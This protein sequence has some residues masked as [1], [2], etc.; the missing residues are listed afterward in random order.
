MPDPS[1]SRR[2]IHRSD[3]KK[4]NQKQINAQDAPH[5]FVIS[6]Y[7]PLAEKLDESENSPQAEQGTPGFPSLS[8]SGI[9]AW[10]VGIGV[11][12]LAGG[13]GWKFWLGTEVHR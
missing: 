3:S 12:A 4:A 1:S 5:S 7:T 9:V 13:V 8:L 2:L 11:G 10:G 6:S